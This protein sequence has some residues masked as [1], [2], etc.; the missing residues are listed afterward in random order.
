MQR[1]RKRF[2]TAETPRAPRTETKK[3]FLALLASW[4]F[5]FLLILCVAALLSGCDRDDQAIRV[6]DIPKESEP[7]QQTPA[8]DNATA[9]CDE[10]HWTVPPG[11]TSKPDP[12]AMRFATFAVSAD[13]PDLVVTVVPLGSGDLLANVNRWQQQLG[14]PPSSPQELE[15]VVKHFDVAGESASE[16]DLS[17]SG[18]PPKRMLAAIVPHQGRFWFFK[19]MGPAELVAGQ[20]ENFQAFVRS[21]EFKS[22]VMAQATSDAAGEISYAAPDG[23]QK[24]DAAPMRY[25]SFHAGAAEVIVTKLP[26]SGSG[27]YLDNVNRWRAQVELP[28]VGENAP[29]SSQDIKVGGSD[30]MLFD[31]V[32]P[33]KRLIVAV[34]P[35]DQDFW[36]FKI[37]GSGEA[38]QQQKPAF[39]AFL[40]SVQFAK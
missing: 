5:N 12:Q 9:S 20:K 38:V 23:W 3:K 30:A 4:R 15:S 10:I 14:L 8:M 27:S 28:A 37:I 2:L 40:Q 33:S 16:V 25:V 17:G 1:Y 22:V 35:Q 21:V 19:L 6:Y 31:F 7:Q 13:Q 34:T 11:W 39:E 36:Y 32:G 29:Q 18:S 24:E 26:A